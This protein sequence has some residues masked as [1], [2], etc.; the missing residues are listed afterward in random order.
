MPDIAALIQFAQNKHM[1]MA[2]RLRNLQ[3]LM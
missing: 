1:E 2:H 3:D